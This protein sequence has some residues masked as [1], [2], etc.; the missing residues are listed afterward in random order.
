MWDDAN[1]R[2]NPQRS[3]ARRA[4][5]CAAESLIELAEAGGSFRAFNGTLRK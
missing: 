2:E 1:R 5:V 4:R 3:L